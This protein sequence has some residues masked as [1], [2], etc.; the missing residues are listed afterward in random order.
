MSN[1]YCLAFITLIFTIVST[2]LLLLIAIFGPRKILIRQIYSDL[3]REYR[4]PEIGSAIYKLIEFYEVDCESDES[5]IVAK[6]RQRFER[7][8]GKGG[9]I[10]IDQYENSLHFHRRILSQ[11]FR[12][13]ADLRYSG[14]CLTRIR[15]GE[16]CDFFTSNES[17]LMNLLYLIDSKAVPEVLREFKIKRRD[18]KEIENSR[19]ARNFITLLG[20]SK[21]WS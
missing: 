21:S 8:M 3:L 14:S 10:G 4:T 7:E 11:Y 13:V 5:R 19:I 9:E 18:G 12:N 2:L 6:Y 15:K 17:K 20:D 16:V 1:E